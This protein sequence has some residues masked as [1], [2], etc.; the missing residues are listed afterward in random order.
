MDVHISCHLTWLARPHS[1]SF[2]GFQSIAEAFSAYRMFISDTVSPKHAFQQ[3][4]FL[5]VDA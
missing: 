5:D 4:Q 3:L 1:A 2:A